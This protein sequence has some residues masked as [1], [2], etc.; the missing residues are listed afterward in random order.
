M[1]PRQRRGP[2]EGP[3]ETHRRDVLP[4]VGEGDEVEALGPR[5]RGGQDGAGIGDV[6]L[7]EPQPGALELGL[8]VVHPAVH[9]LHPPHLPLPPL[10]PGSNSV[11]T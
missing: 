7:Q 8:G 9:Q 11:S 2:G 6:P 5:P 10:F 4:D 1:G 3:E